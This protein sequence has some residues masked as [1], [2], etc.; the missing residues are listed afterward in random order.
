MATSGPQCARGLVC[1]PNHP[2]LG[3]VVALQLLPVPVQVLVLLALWKPRL[4]RWSRLRNKAPN[5]LSPQ[6]TVPTHQRQR[7][8]QRQHQAS[9]RSRKRGWTG[10]FRHR[11]PSRI[12]SFHCCDV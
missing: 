12:S 5:A 9:L 7:Q 4:F 11:L 3:L 1:H 8:R 6:W 2:A 10:Q